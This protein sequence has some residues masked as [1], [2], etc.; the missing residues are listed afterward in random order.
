MC[1]TATSPTPTFPTPVSAGPPPAAVTV[2]NYEATLTATGSPLVTDLSQ[3]LTIPTGATSLS[4]QL[5][6]LQLLQGAGSPGD[7]FEVA[8]L[9]PITHDSLLGT[10]RLTLSDAILNIQQN[11][12]SKFRV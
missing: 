3:V 4:F 12:L 5:D 9:D 11:G 1:P 8:V 6:N 10:D 2:A 7:A